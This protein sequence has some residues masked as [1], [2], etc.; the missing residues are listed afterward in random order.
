MRL[1]LPLLLLSLFTSTVALKGVAVQSAPS[2]LAHRR[3]QPAKVAESKESDEVAT[4]TD[5]K[6]SPPKD[7][8]AGVVSKDKADKTNKADKNKKKDKKD[9]KDKKKEKKCKKAKKEPKRQRRLQADM[10]PVQ[11]PDMAPDSLPGA[12]PMTLPGAPDAAVEEM[13]YCLHGEA[14]ARVCEDLKQG[15]PP[16]KGNKKVDGD[17]SLEITHDS[18]KSSEEVVEKV[19]NILRSETPIK[20][21]GCTG[22]R[23]LFLGG[24]KEDETSEE[25]EAEVEGEEEEESLSVVGLDFGTLTSQG[26]R[27]T[28][29]FACS[30]DIRLD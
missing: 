30:A 9:K 4:L 15:K 18:D 28:V 17:L 3:A 1:V 12:G 11:P 27:Y 23:R 25:K 5:K 7:S 26:K 24:N 13:P 2:T 14:T 16:K 6:A 22:R 19:G 8:G 20:F 29:P 10:A 21:L